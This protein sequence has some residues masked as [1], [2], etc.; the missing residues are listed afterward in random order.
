MELSE[1]PQRDVRR[2]RSALSPIRFAGL[3]RR[4][5]FARKPL[6]RLDKPPEINPSKPKSKDLPD[7]WSS[8]MHKLS[9]DSPA[10]KRGSSIPLKIQ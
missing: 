7:K 1:D 8:P 2:S 3:V 4:C 9:P 10:R 6:A 5:L